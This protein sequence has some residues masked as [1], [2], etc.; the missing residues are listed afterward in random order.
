MHTYICIYSVRQRHKDR[1]IFMDDAWGSDD[2]EK[3]GDRHQL[4][5]E[6]ETRRKEFHTLGFREGMDAGKQEAVQ[7]GFDQGKCI[8]PPAA[9]LVV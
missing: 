6:W 8:V 7:G 4:D 3:E 5:R 9:N 2:G 1:F